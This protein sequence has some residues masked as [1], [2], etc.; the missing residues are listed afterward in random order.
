MYVKKSKCV[1]RQ[2][3]IEYLGYVVEAKGVR[4]NPSKIAAIDK[5]PE[6]VSLKQLQ[7]F[8][9]PCGHYGHFMKS[10]TSIAS[11][12]TDLLKKDKF[13]QDDSTVK[14]FNALKE[15]LRNDKILEQ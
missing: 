14:A 4:P 12:L 7:A 5:W 6:P 10:F 8:L 1:F 13:H 2:S 9:G 15:A 11:L 3:I